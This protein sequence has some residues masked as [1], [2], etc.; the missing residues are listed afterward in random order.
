MT[1]LPFTRPYLSTFFLPTVLQAGD[2]AFI[3]HMGPWETVKM[4][5]III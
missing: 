2:Q 3:Q 4:Q 5:T 1:Q